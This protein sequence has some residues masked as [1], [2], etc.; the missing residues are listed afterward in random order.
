MLIY[1]LYR[2]GIKR[3]GDILWPLEPYLLY[4]KY[5]WRVNGSQILVMRQPFLLW[6]RL[7][8]SLITFEI[9]YSLVEHTAFTWVM[10]RHLNFYSA[11]I[12]SCIGKTSR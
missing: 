1:A 5:S 9:P 2:G 7:A 12:F 8:F 3:A 4:W 11:V 10:V 6:L